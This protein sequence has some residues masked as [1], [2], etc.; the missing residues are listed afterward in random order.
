[1]LIFSVIQHE[2]RGR[3]VDTFQAGIGSFFACGCSITCL[4]YHILD[5]PRVKYKTLK[6]KIPTTLELEISF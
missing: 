6:F 1:M 2:T 4:I 5:N 3:V